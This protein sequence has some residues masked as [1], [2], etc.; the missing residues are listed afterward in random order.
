MSTGIGTRFLPLVLNFATSSSSQI[1]L[2]G[3]SLPSPGQILKLSPFNSLFWHKPSSGSSWSW[4]TALSVQHM[5][6]CPL[7]RILSIFWKTLKLTAATIHRLP[8]SLPGQAERWRNS[9]LPVPCSQHRTH[10]QGACTIPWP[11]FLSS[12]RSRGAAW[13]DDRGWSWGSPTF[14][15]TA[16]PLPLDFEKTSSRGKQNKFGENKD[17]YSLILPFPPR[18]F[19]PC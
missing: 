18:A 3:I 10:H 8:A 6:F 14:C 5:W 7:A 4:L 17:I 15:P 1:Y 13:L 12:G 16:F 2:P 9:V 19:P 11:G